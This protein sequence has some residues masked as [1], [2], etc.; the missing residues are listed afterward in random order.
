MEK[1]KQLAKEFDLYTEE[2]IPSAYKNEQSNHFIKIGRKPLTFEMQGFE[3]GLFFECAKDRTHAENSYFLIKAND[4]DLLCMVRQDRNNKY[5]LHPYYG[6]FRKF[7]NMYYAEKEKYA[8]ELKEPNQM[9]VVTA[10]KL[11]DWVNYCAQYIAKHEQALAEH[12]HKNEAIERKI[13]K[14]IECLPSADVYKSKDMGLIEIKT[15][16]FVIEYRW[17]K[18]RAYLST[19]IDFKGN[20]S[21][22]ILIEN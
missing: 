20:V 10:K 2:D 3:I 17:Q 19:K 8:K 14:A 1:L 21:D 11:T 9:G 12:T 22:V 5:Y 4:C 6:L 13:N 16:R 7:Q 15:K 18:D